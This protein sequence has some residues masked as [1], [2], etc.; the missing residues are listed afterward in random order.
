MRNEVRV[1]ANIVANRRSVN[2][3]NIH[4]RFNSNEMRAID[5]P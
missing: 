4:L 2:V 5:E 1:M 3:N